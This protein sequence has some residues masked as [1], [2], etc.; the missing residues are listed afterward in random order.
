MLSVADNFKYKFFRGS[1]PT[2][3]S[4][5]SRAICNRYAG[6]GHMAI[7]CASL[8]A[9]KQI[10]VPPRPLSASQ[11][12]SP[13]RYRGTVQP[14]AGRPSAGHVRWCHILPCLWNDRTH[15]CFLLLFRCDQDRRRSL[16]APAAWQYLPSAFPEQHCLPRHSPS[17]PRYEIQL[18]AT[19]LPLVG[20]AAWDVRG[21]Y[22]GEAARRGLRGEAEKRLV[23]VPHLQ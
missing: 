4:R 19:V 5:P 18:F 17:A 11:T 23:V 16:W 3:S 2:L 1:S 22:T 9:P 20:Q 10:P 6:D 14:S 13:L 12:N 21:I 7:L 8:H 15:C